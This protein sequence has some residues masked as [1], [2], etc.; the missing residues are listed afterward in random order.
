MILS[1]ICNLGTL[2]YLQ[3]D[4]G[5]EEAAF[6]NLWQGRMAVHM[7]RRGTR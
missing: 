3:V 4:Q 6:L 1:L 7:G 2:I 5:N